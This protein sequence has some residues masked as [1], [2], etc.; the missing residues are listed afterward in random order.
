MYL[1]ATCSLLCCGLLSHTALEFLTSFRSFECKMEGSW[2]AVGC[3]DL[4]ETAG[5]N[6]AVC[7][8]E[9]DVVDS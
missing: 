9:G 2:H 3:Q 4:R 1:T 7:I 8:I 5:V 6:R